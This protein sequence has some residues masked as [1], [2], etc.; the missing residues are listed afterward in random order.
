[1][2]IEMVRNPKR[3]FD[4]S[5]I[6][7]NKKLCEAMSG[8]HDVTGSDFTSS[9]HGL[10]KND[11]LNLRRKNDLFSDGFILLGAE[12]NLNERR[13]EV[14]ERFICEFY[15]KENTAELNDARY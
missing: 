11:G 15:G 14:I 6:K 8:F 4:F 3:L 2:C 7:L 9:F 1:M 13:I 10:G 5:K 12:A